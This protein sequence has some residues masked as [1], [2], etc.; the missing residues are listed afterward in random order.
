M[1]SIKRL[2]E[3]AADI[4]STEIIDHVDVESKFVFHTDW[5]D[6]WHK[7]FDEACKA[8]EAEVAEKYM[9]LPLDADGVPINCGDRIVSEEGR[10]GDVLLIGVSELMT[11]LCTYHKTA[12]VH[13]VKPRTLEDVLEDA[14]DECDKDYG[15]DKSE[16]VAMY[17]ADIRELLG[18][19]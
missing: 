4:N 16:L 17:A 18:V 13:H 15:I 3:L 7:A 11:R 6:S 9:E 5:M 14:F 2:R 8:V 10:K 1:E 19:E 12:E